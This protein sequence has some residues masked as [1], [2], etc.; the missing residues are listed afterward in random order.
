MKLT[1][2]DLA[3][4]LDEM[5]NNHADCIDVNLWCKTTDSFFH[6]DLAVKNKNSQSTY[7]KYKV[8]ITDVYPKFLLTL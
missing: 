3:M 8:L 5:N 6:I 4:M 7:D 2:E 1:R